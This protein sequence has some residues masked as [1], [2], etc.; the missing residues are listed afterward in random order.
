[1]SRKKF[2]LGGTSYVVPGGIPENV[3]VL[4]ELVSEVGLLFFDSKAS[5][6]YDQ[7]DLPLVLGEMG[8]SY[9]VHLPLDLKWE[10]G[11]PEVFN[12]VSALVE[13][14]AFLGPDK[15]VLH[16]PARAEQLEELAVL[17]QGSGLNPRSLLVE[18]INGRDFSNLWEVIGSK[19]LGICLDIGHILAYDQE[20]ILEKDLVWERTSLVHVYGREDHAGHAPLPVIS[21]TGKR[22]LQLILSQVREG[23]SVLLEVFSLEE[24]LD[25][26]EFLIQMADP[27][28]MDF[29]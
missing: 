13:K 18:N 22:T 7:T 4:K 1:M 5:L 6:G 2:I 8:L 25:S 21:E 3:Q 12:V 11:V 9:H 16:P 17:W 19:G 29:V 28:G 27:W 10:K 20:H 23:T 26:K 14:A 24:L 15:F